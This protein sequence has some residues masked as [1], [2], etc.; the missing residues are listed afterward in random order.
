MTIKTAELFSTQSTEY[1]KFRPHYPEELYAYLSSLTAEHRLAWDCGTGSGQAAVKIADY[2]EKVFAT[3][4]SE[5]QL[6]NAEQRD[7]IHYEA[8]RAEGSSLPDHSADLIT[9]AQAFHWFDHPQFFKE[10]RR[11]LKPGGTLAVWSYNFCKIAPAIDAAVYHFYEPVLGPYWEKQRKLVEE[12]YANCEFPL[13]EL[14]PPTFS[15]T[16]QW[17]VEHLIG[18]LS[19]WSSLQT[20]IK[21]NGTNPLEAT[22]NELRALWNDGSEKTVNWT[23]ALRVGHT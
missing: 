22:A 17:K 10:V 14:K 21:K 12:G 15:M 16:A 1:A 4:P 20:Y 8:G 23:L 18:Y 3:D 7:N 5:K 6:Q 13:K 2:Y 11:V 9:V 19:T